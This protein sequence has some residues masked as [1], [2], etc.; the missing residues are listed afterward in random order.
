MTYQDV[1]D[2]NELVGISPRSDRTVYHRLDNDNEIL[3]NRVRDSVT[4]RINRRKE[5]Q[6]HYRC[7]RFCHPHLRVL[8]DQTKQPDHKLCNKLKDPEKTT[9]PG[10]SD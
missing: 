7:C 6:T 5:L 9:L 1:A 3:C 4:P 8:V 10:L 2:P